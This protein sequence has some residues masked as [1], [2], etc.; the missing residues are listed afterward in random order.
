MKYI[1]S[2]PAVDYFI[3]QLEVFDYQFKKLGYNLEDSIVILVKTKPLSDNVKRYIDKNLNRILLVEDERK[4]KEYL[5]NIQIHGLYHLYKNH[6]HLIEGQRVF[7]HD[8]DMVFT[9]YVN[10]DSICIEDK[11]YGSDTISYVGAQYIDSKSPLITDSMCKIVGIDSTVVRS[12]K[13]KSIG[14]QYIFPTGLTYQFWNK[15]E[16]DCNKLLI[17]SKTEEAQLKPKDDP[18]TL[19]WW[20]I[21]MWSILWN[22]WYSDIDTEVNND[23]KFAWSNWNKDKWTDV[24]IYHNAGVSSG[25]EGNFYKGMYI[26]TMPFKANFDYVTKKDTCNYK[27]LEII[28]ELSGLAEIYK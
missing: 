10:W 6:Y 20:T 4:D 17:Y 23:M 8:A 22:L 7:L 12:N 24:S 5:P 14:A 15:V 18:Y 25:N 11:V 3:W 16:D 13:D 1:S 21:S 9:K 19:Q 27:Y 28:T 26:N 2:Q